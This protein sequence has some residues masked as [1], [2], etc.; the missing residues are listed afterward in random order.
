MH[1]VNCPV[2]LTTFQTK[3]S[4]KKYC[5]SPCQKKFSK[6]NEWEK[7]KSN[8]RERCI[9]LSS[10]AKNRAKTKKLL[11][12][13]AGAYLLKLWLEQDGCCA[14]SGEE[15]D[16]SRPED[17]LANWNAPSLDRI[18]PALGYTKGNV[19]LVCYQINAA[20]QHYGT[21]HFLKLCKLVSD[22]QGE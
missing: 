2:C 16:L 20:M 15:F 10:M 5:S 17:G 4:H 21:E 11:Y 22:Y 18:V 14:V 19:R 8:P 9:Q 7:R 13:I 6:A 3:H 1:S 12:D